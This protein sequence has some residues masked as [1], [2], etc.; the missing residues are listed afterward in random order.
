M[1]RSRWDSTGD[2][3]IALGGVAHVPWRAT[4]AEE[5]LRGQ[6]ITEERVRKAARAELEQA[7]ALRDNGYKV[8]LAENLITAT[9]LE[10][11]A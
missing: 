3:R 4:I 11:S 1:A 8:E 5:L 10:L 2:V 7:R 6:A 9:L